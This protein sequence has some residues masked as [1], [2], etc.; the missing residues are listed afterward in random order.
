M[1]ICGC[2]SQAIVND[3]GVFLKRTLPGHWKED[4]Y[5]RKDLNNFLYEMGLNWF[6][7]VY[8]TQASWENEQDIALSDNGNVFEINGKKGPYAT[9]FNFALT[10][11]NRSF[12]D[13]DLGEL[14]GLTDATAEIK[15]NSLITYLRKK[16]TGKIFMTATRTINPENPNEMIYVTKH[17][18]S[19][20]ALTSIFDRRTDI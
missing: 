16:G 10:T 17:L 3:G 9:P 20:V 13:V 15:G 18:G 12:S 4:Q 11:D 7:R 5:K 2:A 19:G 14:G 1:I 8:V 6:K